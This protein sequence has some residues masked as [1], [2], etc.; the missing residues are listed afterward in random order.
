[1]E[2]I[3]NRRH[4]REFGIRCC[5]LIKNIQ[6]VSLWTPWV[7][8][9]STWLYK[10]NWMKNIS[11]PLSLCL[12]RQ[13][14][15]VRR[16]SK[17]SV[18]KLSGGSGSWLDFYR[19]SCC[20][21]IKVIGADFLLPDCRIHNSHDTFRK[22]SSGDITLLCCSDPHPPPYCLLVTMEKCVCMSHLAN[23]QIK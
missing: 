7:T 13:K 6:V 21:L 16:I 2:P 18:W 5:S 12:L 9:L 22:G 4:S 1:M 10:R 14:L 8:N 15:L 19:M 11:V 23:E 20:Q 3:F 17:A